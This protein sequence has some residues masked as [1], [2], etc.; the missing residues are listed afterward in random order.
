MS[1]FI[2]DGLTTVKRVFSK[3]TIKTVAQEGL[4]DAEIELLKAQAALEWAQSHVEFQ[5]NRVARLK[6]YNQTI[7]LQNLK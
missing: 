7:E 3:P 5:T 6:K 4:Y 2:V 1:N